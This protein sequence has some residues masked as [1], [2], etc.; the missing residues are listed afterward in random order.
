MPTQAKS[1]VVAGKTWKLITGDVTLPTA[2]EGDQAD[3]VF[4]DPPYNYGV[5]YGRGRRADKLSE[6]DYYAFTRNWLINAVKRTRPGGAVW[7][8]APDEWA[9]ETAYML[10]WTFGLEMR[11][12]IKWHETFGTHQKGKFSR[13]SR[14]LLY[15]V[16]RGGVPV[17]TPDRVPSARQVKYKDKR[18]AAHGKVPDDV[19]VFSRV[20]GTFK[21][22]AKGV[23]TQMPEE[24]LRRIV[25]ATSKP[26]GKVLEYFAGSGSMG[27]VCVQEGRVYE[28]WES[29]AKTAQIAAARIAEVS[30]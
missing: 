27:R 30:R 9:A 29:H 5:D 16:R 15:F 26:G 4:S 6:S 12:W 21:E 2:G 19:W 25:R 14:H 13:C 22:R 1:N 17:F 18:A 10:R 23:P 7:V 28:G 8:V 3:L 24:L 20:C 11:N